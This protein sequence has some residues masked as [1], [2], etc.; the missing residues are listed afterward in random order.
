MSKIE[1][2]KRY[3][4]IINRLK[5]RYTFEEIAEYLKNQSVGQDMNFTISKRTFQRDINDIRELFNFDI[6][7][8]N[9]IYFIDKKEDN[10]LNERI[11]D[12]FNTFN[13]LNL[14][15]SLT[16]HI[17]F[18]Q[19]KP[20]GTENL[21]GLLHAIQKQELIKI[22]YLKFWEDNITDR[23]LEPYAL[24]EFKNRWYLMAKERNNPIVK[25]FALDR[26]KDLTLLNKKF[27][28]TEPFDIESHFKNSFGIISPNDLPL[29][30]VILSFTPFQGKYIKTLPLHHTQE[31]LID[32]QKELRIKLQ[33]YVTYDF[34]ME[35]LSMGD[36][37]KVLQ[38]ESLVR[39]MK[40]TLQK[41]L[42]RYK[43]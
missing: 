18:E 26:I 27:Q 36:E 24:K 28:K 35:L 38:P 42:K 6:K 19:R 29:E 30:E 39:E 3:F 7:C 8:Q 2:Y 31:I 23:E 16:S 17:Q 13:A 41:A 5:Y 22:K 40:D 33:L 14:T 25:S 10:P 9:N 32:N 20:Q 37:V 4:L 21:Y 34:K 11:Q 1:T 15:D 43:S 12:A